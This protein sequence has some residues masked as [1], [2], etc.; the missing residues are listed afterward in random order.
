[1]KLVWGLL[2]ATVVSAQLDR[3]NS[4]VGVFS[5]PGGGPSPERRWLP[6]EMAYPLKLSPDLY[7]NDEYPSITRDRGGRLW[8]AWMS[9]RPR[10]AK[11]LHADPNLDNWLWPDDGDDHIVVRYYDGKDWSDEEILSAQPGVNYKPKVVPEGSGVRV[12]WTALRKGRWSLY[13]RSW[14]RGKWDAEHAVGEGRD[15]VEI[16]AAALSDGG[17][18]VVGQKAAAP[19]LELHALVRRN[20]HWTAGTRL[21][22]GAGRCH[23]P[24]LL[25]LPGGQWLVAW[26]EER[27]G[28]YDIWVRGSSGPMTRVAGSELW[29]TAPSLARTPDTRVWLA[30]EQKEPLGGRFDYSGRSIFAKYF[31]G[32]QWK[33]VA[34]PYANAEPGSTL[35]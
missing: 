27:E 16:N 17:V 35:R 20:G 15:L 22:E 11:P 2:L 26:D 1:M 18:L 12:L 29:E 25:S 7:A 14:S 21:D 9:C 23:R 24:S 32:A 5:D 34:S 28:N 3:N 30:W 13:E 8:V 19:R 33:W 6:P 31:D 4:A 10:K